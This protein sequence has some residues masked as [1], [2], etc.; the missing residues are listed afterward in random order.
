MSSSATW[1]EIKRLAA[2]FQVNINLSV[3][4]FI[5]LNDYFDN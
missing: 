5:K 1:E 4:F 2:D 3:Y